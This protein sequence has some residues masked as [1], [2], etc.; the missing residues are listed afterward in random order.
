M[1]RGSEWSLLWLDCEQNL[2]GALTRDLLQCDTGRCWWRQSS[3]QRTHRE[4]RLRRTMVKFETCDG[5]NSR[6]S[7]KVKCN[8]GFYLFSISHK[9]NYNS[10]FFSTFLYSN[11]LTNY[12]V[13]N[14][15]FRC[16]CQTPAFFERPKLTSTST[17][18]VYYHIFLKIKHR[19]CRTSIWNIHK[20]FFTKLKTCFKMSDFRRRIDF[21]WWGNP[22]FF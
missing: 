17:E 10:C 13:S 21:L 18:C 22:A 20:I 9:K 14:Y 7:A 5:M 4:Y 15:Y 16:G 11:K 2:R 6:K 8:I 3:T 1:L 12:Q 19:W